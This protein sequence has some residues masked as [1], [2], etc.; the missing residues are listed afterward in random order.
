MTLMIDRRALLAVG[1]AALALPTAARPEGE[2]GAIH[3]PV[4][5]QRNEVLVAVELNGHGPFVFLIDTG[6]S[7]SAVTAAAA[8]RAALPA[9]GRANVSGVNGGA[10]EVSSWF[11]RDVR[12]GGS[13][14]V[15]VTT[16][17]AL[18]GKVGR[19]GLL[20][21]NALLGQPL[22]LALADGEVVLY[23]RARPDVTA[24]TRLPTSFIV[25]QAGG[26]AS[27]SSLDPHLV[28][29]ARLGGRTLRLAI[30]TGA[31][32]AVV[33]LPD[34]S[35]ALWERTPA[36]EV[37]DAG[38]T[39]ASRGRLVRVG[40]LELGG[41][42]VPQVVVNLSDP[43]A[44]HDDDFVDGLIGVD[45]LRQ[46]EFVVD[47]NAGATWI[48]R[49][50]AFGQA[51]R[52]D[53]SGLSLAKAAGGLAVVRVARDSPAW[54]AGLSRGDVV[55]PASPMSREAFLWSLSDAPGVVVEMDATRGG[56][57]NPVRLVLKELL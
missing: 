33:L 57:T 31:T 42:T 35:R 47:A 52:Y 1:G 24:Y 26:A 9:A 16:F 45:L 18:T 6:A 48:R 22:R 15:G 12:L 54:T 40:P 20:A 34:A 3:V 23:P 37:V 55:T 41:L 17:F 29:T 25:R 19:D 10:F 49:G 53:R 44:R 36:L 43:A 32:S 51:F 56:A 11:A 5:V 8:R 38:I 46:L 14:A 39:G 30:D 27:R 50:P 4:T 7:G 21:G 28:V 2:T 13:L